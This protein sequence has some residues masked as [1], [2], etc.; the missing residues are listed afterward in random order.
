MYWSFEFPVIREVASLLGKISSSFSPV[1][2]GSLHYQALERVEIQAL[3]FKKGSFDKKMIMIT[4]A[5]NDI[6]GLIISLQL[7]T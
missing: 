6:G 3:K 5:G 4:S 7:L 1:Q 2:F